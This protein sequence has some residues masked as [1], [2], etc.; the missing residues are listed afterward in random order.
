[1]IDDTRTEDNFKLVIQIEELII[2][3]R[4]NLEDI[5]IQLADAKKELAYRRNI[6]ENI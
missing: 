5:K 2:A 6:G 1:M 4:K 3:S